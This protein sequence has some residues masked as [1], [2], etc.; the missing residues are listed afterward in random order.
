MTFS[1]DDCKHLLVDKFPDTSAKEW[2]R[3]K[4]YKNDDKVVCRDF[5]HAVKGIVVIAEK[6]SQ[7]ILVSQKDKVIDPSKILY[8][9][10]FAPEDIKAAKKIITRII[11]PTDEDMENDV[12]Y[13]PSFADDGFH[14]LPALLDFFFYEDSFDKEVCKSIV[15]QKN[16]LSK[17]ADLPFEVMNNYPKDEPDDMIGGYC[18][19]FLPL[20]FDE[21][22][23]SSFEIDKHDNYNVTIYEVFKIM[24]ENGFVYNKKSCMFREWLKDYTIIQRPESDLE[25]EARE[26]RKKATI[27]IMNDDSE[28]LKECIYKDSFNKDMTVGMRRLNDYCKYEDKPKCLQV[29]VA[30]QKEEQDK[31][32]L[33]FK[34]K[35][36]E[37]VFDENK[38]FYQKTFNKE[39]VDDAKA[40]FDRLTKCSDEDKNNLNYKPIEFEENGYNATPSL[41]EFY[42]NA[43]FKEYNKNEYDRILKEKD[44]FAR[45]ANIGL[46]IKNIYPKNQEEHLLTRCVE[47]ILPSYFINFYM[48]Y[49]EIEIDP[50]NMDKVTIYD[51]FKKLLELGFVYNHKKCAFQELLHDYTIVEKPEND[52]DREVRDTRLKVQKAIKGD[53]AEELEKYIY[54]DSFDKNMTIGRHD[55][56]VFCR[57]NNRTKCYRLLV[58][59]NI[60]EG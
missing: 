6:D 29:L 38:I 21:V 27:A 28:M 22:A 49:S 52:F 46:S 41:L 40:L 48:N 26:I 10:V 31:K 13:D 18:R 20:Y 5:E 35:R 14:A 8:Q 39:D 60:I 12:Q 50:Y 54:K 36:I 51:V 55:L 43:D 23:E 56:G 15:K 37:K 7:L 2:K 30:K 53:N 1:T 3:I 58:T 25:K 44:I 47:H 57:V 19:D 24:L 32:Y 16:M 45:P 4:K 59:K 33:D 34:N 9:K 17:P 11:F 42:F